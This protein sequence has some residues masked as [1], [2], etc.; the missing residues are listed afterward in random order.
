MQG[1]HISHQVETVLLEHCNH[2][3]QGTTMTTLQTIAIWII[4][5]CFQKYLSL[6]YPYHLIQAFSQ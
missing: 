1:H 2:L 4:A 5:E 6:F 3:P